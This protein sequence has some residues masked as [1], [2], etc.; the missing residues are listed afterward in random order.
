MK[1]FLL[2]LTAFILLDA[3]VPAGCRSNK[4]EEEPMP[5][6]PVSAQQISD[7]W[8]ELYNDLIDECGDSIPAPAYIYLEDID[9]DGRNEVFVCDD[10]SQV[11]AFMYYASDSTLL[12][13][14]CVLDSIENFC[15]APQFIVREATEIKKNHRDVT[16]AFTRIV[17]GKCEYIGH[18]LTR[19]TTKEGEEEVSELLQDETN[20]DLP[21][22]LVLVPYVQCEMFPFP[23]I[24]SENTEEVTEEAE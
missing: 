12:M 19:F 16:R 6:L 20:G 4:E 7:D 8:Y 21:D 23:Y 15:Y 14:D 24:E 11:T 22:S 18:T 9:A 2:Y 17:N 10:Q 3:I 13:G 1:S 5:E